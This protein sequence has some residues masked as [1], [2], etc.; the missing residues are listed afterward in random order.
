MSVGADRRQNSFIADQC[1]PAGYLSVMQ[2]HPLSFRAAVLSS[3]SFLC[4]LALVLLS[5]LVAVSAASPEIFPA[6]VKRVVFLGDS[7]TYG[8]GYVCDITAWLRTREPGRQFEII[9]VGLPSETVSGLSEPEH[10]TRYKFAR[11][12][13][14]ERL[15]RVLAQTKPDLVIACYGM[16]DGIYLP[17][18]EAR[19]Q[20]FRDGIQWLHAAVEKGGAKII[21]VTPPV[22]DELKGGHPGYG[23]VLDKYSDWLVTQRAAGW[24]VI[25]LHTPM[26]QALTAA[27]EKDSA[28]AFAKDGIHPGESGHWLMARTILT[29]LGATDVADAATDLSMLARWRHGPEIL[30]LIRQ[31]QAVMK[32]AWLTATGHKRPMRPG[33]PLAEAQAKAGELEKQIKPLLDDKQ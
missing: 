22:F 10:L 3:Q 12:D 30:Q 21:H 16:N 15:E 8:G 20:A 17:L 7:I 19:F 33:L 23:A 2:I 4:V 28:F 18:D 26:K 25:D 24:Q 11:P 1:R 32:D 5:G 13:L 14:H 6:G 27:R 29:N 9:N 31:Q